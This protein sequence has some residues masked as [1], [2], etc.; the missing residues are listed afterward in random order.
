METGQEALQAPQ[1]TPDSIWTNGNYAPVTREIEA[2]GLKVRGQLPRE[3]TGTLYRN[4]PNPH[5][6]MASTHW[7]G[8]DGMIHA[9]ALAD[10]AAAYRNR[11]VRTPKWRDEDK[12]GRA[13]F[14]AFAGKLPDA[15]EWVGDDRGVANTNIVWHGQRLLALEEAHRPTHMTPDT[16]ETLGYADYGPLQGPFTAHPKV[17]PQTGEM[18]FFGYNADGPLTAAMT[19]GTIGPDARLTRHL[20][21]E[22][23][24]CSMVHDFMMTTRHLLFPVLPL[25]GSRERLDKGLPPYAFE[26]DRPAMI[27]IMRRD[28]PLA[29]L[30][31]FQG[32]SCYVFH[33]LNAWEEGDTIYADV[34]VYDEAPLFPRPDG[35]PGDRSRQLAYLTRWTFDLA[36]GRDSFCSQRLCDIPGEFPRIDDR[37]A[38]RQHR[39]GW[40][41]ASVPAENPAENP[42]QGERSGIVHVDA[43][44]GATRTL[45][46]PSGDAT[47]E[48]VFAPRGPAEGD[49]WLLAVVWRAQSNTS[50]LLVIDAL[51]V[52]AGPVA[53]VEMP[54]RVPFGF[55]GN[56]VEGAGA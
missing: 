10:G 8:G 34:M 43:R 11:W 29:A 22:T 50:E 28:A 6:P 20:K 5:F 40:F 4:G 31:W 13:L 3:L 52:E 2:T 15:P 44:T 53:A 45:W 41:A 14:R 55:H 16:L 42:E 17:D 18:F 21:F 49:G 38:G 56:W 35:S 48:P 46:L 30:R 19:T 7:F 37:L 23:P 27:G 32:P 9:I 12:A 1:K 24:Y 39:H 51:D 25:T 26:A 54:Q 47:S 36:D 33:A